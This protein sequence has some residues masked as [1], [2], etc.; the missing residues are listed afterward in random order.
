MNFSNTMKPGSNL[1]K[2]GSVPLHNSKKINNSKLTQSL[3][4]ST[5]N[6]DPKYPG[7]NFNQISNRSPF[8]KKSLQNVGNYGPEMTVPPTQLRT[9]TTLQTM[10][11]MYNNT[12][13]IRKN[14]LGDTP[15][16]IPAQ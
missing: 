12:Q 9:G 7:M 3:G 2:P 16:I 11:K 14:I 4:S 5:K 10:P 8:F 15:S 13:I 1:E 6:F